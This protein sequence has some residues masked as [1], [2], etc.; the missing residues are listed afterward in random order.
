MLKECSPPTMCHMSHVTFHMSHVRCQVSGVT[1]QVSHV[2][3][4]SGQSVG[5]SRWRVCYQRGLP[6][7]VFSLT[8][9]K[10]GG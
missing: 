3:F 5:A 8:A 6:R 2:S 1:S 7:L 4:F 10:L 9:S